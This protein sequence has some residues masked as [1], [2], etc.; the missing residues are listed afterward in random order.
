MERNVDHPR[1]DYKNFN[2]PQKIAALCGDACAGDPQYRD[3][4]DVKP[5]P[6]TEPKVLI[7]IFR[8]SSADEQLPRCRR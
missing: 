8:S 2:L 3:W 6:R 7:E 5:N 1:S 4:T